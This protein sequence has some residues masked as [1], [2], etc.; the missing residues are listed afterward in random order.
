MITSGR[1]FRMHRDHVAQDGV[2]AP[3]AQRLVGRLG[4]A[5]VA[6]AREPLLGAVDRPRG[7]QLLGADEPEQRRLLGADQ[8]LPAL[9]ARQRQVAGAHQLVVGQPGQKARVLVVGVGGDVEHV[10]DDAEAI[11]GA[12]QL[13]A[14]GCCR[15]GREPGAAISVT[16][17][18]RRVPYARDA[19]CRTLSCKTDAAL[20]VFRVRRKWPG[21]QPAV[22]FG[23]R[24]SRGAQARGGAR[25]GA[26]AVGGACRPSSRRSRRRCPKARRGSARSR[27][28]R[29][30]APRRSLTGQ[31][32]GLFLGPLYTIYK[33]A[34]AVSLAEALAVETGTPVVPVFWMATEDHD[35]AEI[36]HCTIARGAE[37]RR[38]GCACRPTGASMRASRWPR[39][40]SAPTSPPRSRRCARRSPGGPPAPRS[41]RC[42]PSTTGRARASPTPSPAC[43]ARSSPTRGCSCS[44]RVRPA[45][46][47]WR[48]RCIDKALPHAGEIAAR[49]GARDAALAEAGFDAQVHVRPDAALVFAHDERGARQLVRVDE[50]AARAA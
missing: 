35:F 22:A 13:A 29:G 46:P 17:S 8:V 6:R 4:V 20:F 38:S 34:T 26:D 36:D 42:S 19:L 39:R 41:R 33:A 15:V 48:H 5:E 31:Q 7:Q 1:N 40:G 12:H 2:V 50:A 10:A 28:W 37:T 14:D 21:S 3:D 16:A 43:S 27:R 47:R 30:R 25:G 24:R 11:D 49:L 23:V 45:W 9:A 44:T 32:V 18:N